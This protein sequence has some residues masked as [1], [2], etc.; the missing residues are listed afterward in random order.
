MKKIAWFLI[1]ALLSALFCAC[2][3]DPAA[4]NPSAKPDAQKQDELTS[5]LYHL[6]GAGEDMSLNIADSDILIR[7][8]K[9]TTFASDAPMNLSI[10]FNFVIRHYSGGEN[11]FFAKSNVKYVDED[12]NVTNDHVDVRYYLCYSTP[13][14]VRMYETTGGYIYESAT[15]SAETIKE[16]KAHFAYVE[17]LSDEEKQQIEAAWLTAMGGS[18]PQWCDQNGICEGVHYY[19][20]YS[21]Y[22]IL[23]ISGNLA[24]I[25]E[26]TIGSKTFTHNSSMALYAHKDGH[27]YLLRDLYESGDFRNG[28]IVTIYE[29]HVECQQ[30]H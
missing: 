18:L 29:R 5:I 2:G 7:I 9:E 8:A 22:D 11:D 1:I 12:G 30:N 4:D 15:L 21:G 24:V 20:T 14:I 26:E 28:H 3:T 10:K 6:D 23:F 27:F 17:S 16:L 25:S 19:G 13:M